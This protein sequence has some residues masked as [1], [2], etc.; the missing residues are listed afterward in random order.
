M[1]TVKQNLDDLFRTLPHDRQI[2]VVVVTKYASL[3]QMIEAYNCGMRDFGENKIQDYERKMQELPE[4]IGQS[5]QWHFIGHLQQNKVTKTFGNRFTLIHSVD[6]LSLAEKISNGNISGNIRQAVLL[7]INMTRE[8]QKS[9]FLGEAL[10]KDFPQLIE[11]P[12]IDVKGLMAIGPH[13]DD[14][15]ER[16]RHF[17]HLHDLRDGLVQRFG[18]PLP[19]LS[20]GMSQDFEHAIECGATIIRIGNRIFGS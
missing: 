11:L 8:P 1:F 6:S 19:E 2:R 3:P 4:E 10:L 15:A 7:Q 9:G 16:K 18:F 13:T 12:G 14:A 5:I 20:M 17:T